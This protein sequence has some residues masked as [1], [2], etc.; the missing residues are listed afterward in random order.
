MRCVDIRGS[1][2]L[3]GI[4]RHATTVFL[5]ELPQKRRKIAIMCLVLAPFGILGF[6]VHVVAQVTQG[7]TPARTL[8]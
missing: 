1:R 4:S 6:Q 2:R 7:R 8:G 3:G 5:E